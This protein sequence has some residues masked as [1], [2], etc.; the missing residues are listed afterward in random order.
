MAKVCSFI[1]F[2]LRANAYSRSEKK[3]DRYFCNKYGAVMINVGFMR[4]KP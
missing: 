4:R 2:R 1:C 3:G